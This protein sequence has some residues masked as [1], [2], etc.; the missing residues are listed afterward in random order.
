MKQ[1]TAYQNVGD[2]TISLGGSIGGHDLSEAKSATRWLLL[3]PPRACHV[4]L[5]VIDILRV[6]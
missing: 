1:S 6:R 3:L 5:L 4:K 2:K